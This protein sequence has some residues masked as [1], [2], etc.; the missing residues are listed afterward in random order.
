MLKYKQIWH[1]INSTR[2]L[3]KFNLTDRKKKMEQQRLLHFCNSKL[4]LVFSPNYRGGSPCYGCQESV[5]GPSYLC[6]ELGCQWY[7]HYKSCA[8][9]PLGLH[10]PLHPIH[11]LILFLQGGYYCKEY[12]KCELYKD[13]SQYTY[14]CSCYD[15]NLH[16]T[17]ASLLPTLEAEV[18]LHDHLLIPIWKWITFTFN[19]LW[20]RRQRYALSV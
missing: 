3:I 18:E 20:Q 19:L 12:Y 4:P 13:R 11:P 10:H 9:L 7:E 17:R 8:K 16:I 1:G 6:I 14:W 5:Y 2:W 15:F